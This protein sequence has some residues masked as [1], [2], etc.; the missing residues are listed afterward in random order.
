MWLTPF[1]RVETQ[2]RNPGTPC[3]VKKT[4]EM[5]VS[6]AS[7]PA[8]SLWRS[9][10]PCSIPSPP[11]LSDY[12]LA[13]SS[14]VPPNPRN[15]TCNLKCSRPAAWQGGRTSP[16]PRSKMQDQQE[17]A[18]STGSEYGAAKL[19][20]GPRLRGPRNPSQSRGWVCRWYKGMGTEASL[21]LNFS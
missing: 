16:S 10:G 6:L 14:T 18:W 5:L 21:C 1:K 13:G 7:M 12:S 19:K 8:S 17:E 3:P 4:W 20:L 9:A 2:S 11:P 15:D